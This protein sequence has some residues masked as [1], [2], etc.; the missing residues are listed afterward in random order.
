[1][2]VFAVAGTAQHS[3]VRAA[4]TEEK[5]RAARGEKD[6]ARYPTPRQCYRSVFGSRLAPVGKAAVTCRWS[7]GAT[8]KLCVS[9]RG[10]L[11]VGPRF[12]LVEVY[13]FTSGRED[14]Q[15]LG[16]TGPV[17]PVEKCREPILAAIRRVEHAFTSK[18]STTKSISSD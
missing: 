7:S 17:V 5:R 2:S 1:M 3:S 15:S 14:C 4:D 13:L 11:P 6:R 9:L 10:P 18:A 12:D 16:K 8:D